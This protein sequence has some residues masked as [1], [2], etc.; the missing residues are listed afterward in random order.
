MKRVVLTPKAR[1][2]LKNI[3]H[4]TWPRWGREQGIKYLSML[5]ECFQR[6]AETPGLGRRRNEL[7]DGYRS[8]PFGGHVIFYRQ[9]A[10]DR[11][12]V[13]RVLHGSMDVEGHL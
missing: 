7:R 2:D 6:L 8:L 5:D 1:A 13:V 11:I 12:E 3:A 9:I 4:F 10:D